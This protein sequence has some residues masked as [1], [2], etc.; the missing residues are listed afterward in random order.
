M[1][2]FI[3]DHSGNLST[4]DINAKV[5]FSAL[6]KAMDESGIFPLAGLRSRVL[7]AD[8][9]YVANGDENMAYI[10]LNFRI[11]P[12][13]SDEELTGA[14]TL[15]KELVL[16]HFDSLMQG[17]AVALSI[18]MSELPEKLRHNANNIRQYL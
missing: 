5:L 8:E 4:S 13:R 10:H 6:H 7:R 1:A 14:F 2:H 12:G 11:G 3:L 15:I 9:Y 18:E 17:Q 16:Q